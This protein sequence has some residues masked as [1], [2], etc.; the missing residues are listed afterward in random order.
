MLC[1]S[2]ANKVN[3]VK[4]NFFRLCINSIDKICQLYICLV[5]NQYDYILK[6]FVKCDILY[7]VRCVFFV[8]MVNLQ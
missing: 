3:K 1:Q 7:H 4:L 2:Y 6:W 5:S 8:S